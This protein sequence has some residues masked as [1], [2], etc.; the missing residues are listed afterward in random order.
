MLSKSTRDEQYKIFGDLEDVMFSG[1]PG[2]DEAGRATMGEMDMGLV[3]TIGNKM[4][5]KGGKP[6]HIENIFTNIGMMRKKWSDM[7]TLVHSKLPLEAQ[8]IFRNIMGDSFKQWI[9]RTYAI[10]ENKSAIPFLN[11][12]PTSQQFER[13]ANMFMR[14]NRRAISRAK[15]AGT[16][17][18]NPI[19]YEE[20]ET[21]VSNI[22][23]DV[24]Q[25]TNLLKLIKE[26]KGTKALR[27]PYFDIDANFVKDSVADDLVTKGIFQKRL[28][29]SVRTGKYAAKETETGIPAA[30]VIGKGSKAFRE[31]FGEVKDVR[32]KM[33]HGTERLSLVTRKSEFLQK[34]VDDS[35]QRITDGGRGYFYGTK[36]QAERALGNIP[37]KKYEPGPGPWGETASQNP[38]LNA[39]T[40][41]AWG[42]VD[43]INALEVTEKRLINNKTISFL[44]D[45]LFLFPKATSQFAKTIL[46]PITHARNFFS[47]A[48]FQT[49]NGIWFENPKVLAA[50]WR[51][52]MGSLQPQNFRSEYSCSAGIL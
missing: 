34:L 39:F 8:P 7:A 35:A 45:S 52:A 2:I 50:A 15:E 11:F 26:T 47:A 12:K 25:E 27:T 49:A 4:L 43:L 37:V 31:L 10:F 29:Q 23:R 38:V 14:Q 30:T 36:L 17:A 33:L 16:V 24:K 40:D 9:G 6:E 22:L 28:E 32:Q 3:E 1:R 5:N 19:S 41:G 48:T 21:M 13:V 44:Y 42:D 20:A 18:P 51:D 46:S